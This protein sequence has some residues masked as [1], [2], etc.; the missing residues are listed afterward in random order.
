[1]IPLSCRSTR[2]PLRLKSH[3]VLCALGLSLTT[4][5]VAETA[6]TD[7][8]DFV[9]L[10]SL[11]D[12]QTELA[13]KS[14]MNADYTPGMAT[15]LHGRDLLARGVRTVWEALSLVPG[16]S[17]GMEATG[18]RQVLSRGVGYGYA[19]GNIKI[20]LDGVS[21]SSAFIGTAD[22]VL[23]MPIEQ[24][25]RIE[26]IRGPGSSVYGEHAYAG[27]VD[28]ITR[29]GERTLHGQLGQSGPA[30]G[31]LNVGG[32]AIWTWGLPKQDLRVSVNLQG[33]EDSADVEAGPDAL[34]ATGHSELSNAP[35]PTNETRRFRSLLADLQWGDSFASIAILDDAYGDP[36]GVNHMLPPRST[37]LT[38]TQQNWSAQLGHNIR[39]NDQ[40]N[41]TVRLEG[42]GYQDRRDQLYV[43]PVTYAGNQEPVYV[44]RDYTERRYRGSV[45]IHW[46]P[47]YQH[48]LL[49]GLEASQTNVGKAT[50]DWEGLPFPVPPNWLD[51]DM[52]RTILS[53]FI[54]DEYRPSDQL[55]LTGTLRYDDYSDVESFF[56]PRLAAV[57]RIDE[58]N[59]LKAQYAVAFRPPTFF[60]Q[61]YPAKGSLNTS[62]IDTVELGYIR[63]QPSWEL[64]LMAFASK[65]TNPIIFDERSNDGYINAPDAQLR[66][67]ELEFE[68]RFGR[69]VRLDGNLS[70]VDA[71]RPSTGDALPGGTDLL[72][73]LAAFW[74]FHPDWTAVLQGRY[75]GDR[76]R[77][78]EDPRPSLQ[79]YTLLDLTLTYKPERKGPVLYLGVKNLTN[80]DVRYPEQYTNLNGVSLSY[81][82]DYPRPSRR[83]WLSAGYRF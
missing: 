44:D 78:P 71:Q 61:Q 40:L 57:W 37:H 56:S 43:L 36:F 34:W 32:G 51:T 83:L 10:L 74:R 66:G 14:G 48:K 58:Q 53:A 81:P 72:A 73:N 33:L 63:R 8:E 46:Q 76:Y 68:G 21:M 29:R 60:E 41:A 30:G 70:Y 59:I 69:D 28:V 17:Q 11:L 67:I 16:M 7:E 39:V 35:G 26:V 49:I 20:L 27:V 1:M 50:W 64:R 52:N 54:Q 55:T 75:V 38:S 65:L 12:N 5:V 31:G 79:G 77:R 80:E 22:A 23:E 18:E 15:I 24:V 3:G 4:G 45:D 47:R 2:S 25:Q 13:T 82:G 62:T 19:S 42:L 9:D 6:R